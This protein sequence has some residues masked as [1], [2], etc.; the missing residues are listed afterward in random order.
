MGYQMPQDV[1]VPDLLMDF[2]S[3][4]G[5]MQEA[6]DQYMLGA[7]PEGGFQSQ[8]ELDAVN[9]A[10]TVDVQNP[11]RIIQVLQQGCRGPE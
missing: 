11:Y 9:E 5:S 6:Y 2:N 1:Q 7:T 3:Q 4:Y 10:F 8:E